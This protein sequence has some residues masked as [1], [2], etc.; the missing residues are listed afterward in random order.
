MQQATQLFQVQA[1]ITTSQ[2][3]YSS[4][5]ETTNQ[6]VTTFDQ[7]IS[8]AS[9]RTSETQTTTCARIWQMSSRSEEPWE[10]PVLRRVEVKLKVWKGK[11]PKLTQL[12]WHW[13]RQWW[14]IL[15]WG[16]VDSDAQCEHAIAGCWGGDHG[17]GYCTV[18][19][20]VVKTVRWWL[21][22]SYVKATRVRWLFE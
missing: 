4:T 3:S 16:G 20:G 12:P 9:L 5:Q 19:V 1:V 13:W 18:C 6:L 15:Q 21:S 2:T 8:A 17:S 22:S 10:H 7:P 11:L 14:Q